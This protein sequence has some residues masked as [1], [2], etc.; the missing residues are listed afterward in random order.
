[1]LD[2]AL[3]LV[4]F[5]D[6]NAMDCAKAFMPKAGGTYTLTTLGT[7]IGGTFA[8]SVSNVTL[9]EVTIAE[10]LTT[11]PVPGGETWCLPSWNW[12][13]QIAASTGDAVISW[14]VNGGMKCPADGSSTPTGSV[15]AQATGPTSRTQGSGCDTYTTTLTGL[16]PG[17]YNFHLVLTDT[18][19]PGQEATGDA[20]GIS[21]VAGT[22]ASVGPVDISC[23]FC[24]L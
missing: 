3:C 2:C 5:K 8:G 18:Q 12:S 6:C 4:I 19:H 22:Q 10:D 11:T 24:P 16:S 13:G 7:T 14:T 9:Q 15:S 23:S 21:I 1:M 17:T 20:N